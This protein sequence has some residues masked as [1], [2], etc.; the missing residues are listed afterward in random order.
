[1]IPIVIIKQQGEPHQ[2]LPFEIVT[3]CYKYIYIYM[4]HLYICISVT[5][6]MHLDV[7]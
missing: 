3:P 7:V 2:L 5:A 4:L 6:R 1:M